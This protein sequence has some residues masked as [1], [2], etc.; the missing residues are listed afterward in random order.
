MSNYELL[1]NGIKEALLR[2]YGAKHSRAM[3]PTLED[4]ITILERSLLLVNEP[5]DY[6]SLKI[7]GA[8]KNNLEKE[9]QFK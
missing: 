3:S 6:V 7:W 5:F 4:I 2:S 8:S 9:E 1:I